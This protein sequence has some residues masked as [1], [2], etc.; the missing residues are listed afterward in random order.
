MGEMFSFNCELKIITYIHVA[1][2]ELRG[3]VVY[4]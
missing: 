4:I 3:R 1:V 2:S